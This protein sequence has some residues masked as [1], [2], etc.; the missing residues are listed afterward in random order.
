MATRIA[1]IL[2]EHDGTEYRLLRTE[3]RLELQVREDEAWAS[4][5]SRRGG[6]GVGP[7]SESIL[8][9]LEHPTVGTHTQ[10]AIKALAAASLG[11][12]V[13]DLFTGAFGP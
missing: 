1:G 13:R 3:G 10:T 12:L 11:E 9:G 5:R 4:L 6:K 8:G 2:F 7:M